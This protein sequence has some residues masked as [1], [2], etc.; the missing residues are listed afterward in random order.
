MPIR[1]TK[2]V[3]MG[4]HGHEDEIGKRLSQSECYKKLFLIAFPKESGAI[5]LTT[6]SQALEG[7]EKTLISNNS[8][9]DQMKKNTK[10][11]PS[12]LAEKGKKLFFGAAK[13]NTC[14]SAPLF[15]DDDFHDVQPKNS[16][17]D[18]SIDDYGLSDV[19]GNPKHKNVF[20]TPSLRNAA[21]TSPYWHDGSAKT[22]SDAI[23]GHDLKINQMLSDREIAELIAFIDT[24]SDT[25]FVNNPKYAKPNKECIY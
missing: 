2:P 21:L 1:G 5:N 18:N 15:S 7:F 20:R 14:H 13:C 3:E 9:Y 10:P 12:K 23:R 8:I 16:K 24:L 25:T 6:V 17:K 4:M 11:L 22:L 19:S